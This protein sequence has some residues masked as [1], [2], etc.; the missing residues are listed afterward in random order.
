MR[1]GLPKCQSKHSLLTIAKNGF[2][3][4]DPKQLKEAYVGSVAAAKGKLTPVQMEI[5]EDD[6]GIGVAGQFDAEG[7]GEQ[8]I[9]PETKAVHP[10]TGVMWIATKKFPV[11]AA[12]LH[13]DTLT[14]LDQPK[15]C[16]NGTLLMGARLARANGKW[17]LDGTR[18]PVV[19][20]ADA[21]KLAVAA[22]ATGASADGPT[23]QLALSGSDRIG[24]YP[25]GLEG[26]VEALDCK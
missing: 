4:L 3:P 22:G 26:S 21:P 14:L 17:T 2:E 1:T 25:V 11:R 12:V 5:L 7:C 9:P 19:A 20:I 23:V 8:V 13:G 10:S 15:D 18:L 6:V 16:S 24:D